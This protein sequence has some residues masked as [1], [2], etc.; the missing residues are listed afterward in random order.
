MRL[1]QVAAMMPPDLMIITIDNII[2][3]VALGPGASKGW[4]H[5]DAPSPLCSHVILVMDKLLS[6]VQDHA[7]ALQDETI[8]EVGFRYLN[9]YLWSIS[10]L[11]SVSRDARHPRSRPEL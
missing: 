3:D 2:D 5:E 4:R 7:A 10:E 1:A 8:I 9:C 6:A 11:V